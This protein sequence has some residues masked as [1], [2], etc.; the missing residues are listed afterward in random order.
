[1]DFLATGLALAETEEFQKEIATWD[2]VGTA[3]GLLGFLSCFPIFHILKA[4][5]FGRVWW[6]SPAETVT[7]KYP[8]LLVNDQTFH[9]EQKHLHWNHS[10]FKKTTIV[11]YSNKEKQI[12]N[13]SA[14]FWMNLIYHKHGGYGLMLLRLRFGRSS[15]FLL[16]NT[17]FSVVLF[18][19]FFPPSR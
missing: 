4:F 17:C 16:Q 9:S 1:M 19:S 3:Q 7:T 11:V 8:F 13:S 18:S 10:K 12:P 6:N 15:C 14:W 5:Q 2:W